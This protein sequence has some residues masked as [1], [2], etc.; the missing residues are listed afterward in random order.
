MANIMPPATTA[1]HER[2][3]ARE[4]R[5]RL[6]DEQACSARSAPAL[7]I[8]VLGAILSASFRSDMEGPASALPGEV[9]HAVRESIAGAAGVAEAL[10]PQG[11]TLLRTAN[12]AFVTGVHWAS[13]G[14]A[15]MTLIGVLVV[16]RWMPGKSAPVVSPDLVKAESAVG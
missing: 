2:A 11:A 16:A 3:A 14:A 6:L 9:G 15:L 12:E 8:A 1:H 13:G 10:G 5:R 7:G 4:G